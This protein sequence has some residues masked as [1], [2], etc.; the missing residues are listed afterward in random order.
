MKTANEAVEVRLQ[1]FL[2]TYRLTPPATTGATPCELLQG[3]RLKSLLDLVS[4]T[5]EKN[6]SK[7]QQRQCSS[8]NPKTRSRSFVVGQQVWVQTH[9][10]NEPKWSLGSIQ[11][12]VG[13]VSFIIN[14][15][16]RSM[17]RHIDH[18]L[19]AHRMPAQPAADEVECEETAEVIP[20][21]PPRVATPRSR[22]AT[23]RVSPVQSPV[24][25]NNSPVPEARQNK[26]RRSLWRRH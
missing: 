8:Y 4:P 20:K 26:S 9:S 2:F 19:E 6:V 11:S 16:G 18:I 25:V 14:V 12:S 21:T 23:P 22:Y 7:A 24:I 3:R 10:K 5:V 17:K 15:S 13:P 1:K